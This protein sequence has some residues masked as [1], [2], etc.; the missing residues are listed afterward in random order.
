VSA[1]SAGAARQLFERD[2]YIRAVLDARPVPPAHDVRRE[3]RDRG[4]TQ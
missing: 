4:D 2:G 1:F 3:M